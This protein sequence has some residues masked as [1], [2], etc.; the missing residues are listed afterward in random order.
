MRE[1]PCQK[2]PNQNL[3]IIVGS[4][5]GRFR[6]FF[7][8]ACLIATA[9]HQTRISNASFYNSIAPATDLEIK[10]KTPRT[11]RI[12]S[13]DFSHLKAFL[14][15]N[16]THKQAKRFISMRRDAHA[17]FTRCVVLIAVFVR[18][19]TVKLLTAGQYKCR[20]RNNKFKK[21]VHAGKQLSTQN[22]GKGY[23]SRLNGRNFR[24]EDQ[25][26]KP[27]YAVLVNVAICATALRAKL[28]M[29]YP[30]SRTLTKRPE[31]TALAT[32]ITSIVI[33]E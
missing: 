9:L 19:P 21:L 25:I 30:P 27:H 14:S 1:N 31:H 29:S 33:K 7:H 4:S 22:N 8:C 11:T 5:K 17:D 28:L 24:L 13:F 15:Q 23:H 32:L 6:Q 2:R 16:L 18:T 26:R 3:L 20:D 12:K 10:F